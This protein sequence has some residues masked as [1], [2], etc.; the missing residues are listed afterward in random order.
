MS[1]GG[2]R[3]RVKSCVH[4][5]GEAG[6]CACCG[7]AEEAVKINEP[8]CADSNA[9]ENPANATENIELILD[10]L[11]SSLIPDGVAAMRKCLEVRRN[12]K[13]QWVCV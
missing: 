8:N 4:G 3:P 10:E 7:A 5:G 6:V 11:E 12:G 13:T 2:H 9:T 1:A